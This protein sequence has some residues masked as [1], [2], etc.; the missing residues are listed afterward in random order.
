MIRIRVVGW[1]PSRLTERSNFPHEVVTATPR[2]AKL[3]LER[4]GLETFGDLDLELPVVD[5]GHGREGKTFRERAELVSKP[6]DLL[7]KL[8]ESTV[9]LPELPLGLWRDGRFYGAAEGSMP[10]WKVLCR[11]GRF[12]GATE[13]STARRKVLRRDGR[14]YGATEG[15]TARRKVLRRNG[16]FY[17]ATE[18]ST[19]Q[20]KVLRPD[21][22][23]C[24]PM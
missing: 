20:R 10:R 14:F 23:F 24:G 18:G 16:R 3:R 19:A 8:P 2:L 15:S 1:G 17:G 12:Y 11:D 22:R 5:P 13:G 7:P 9:G 6:A 21:V 4:A